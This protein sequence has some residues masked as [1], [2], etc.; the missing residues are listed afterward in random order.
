MTT[1]VAYLSGPMSGVPDYNF[2]AF[3]EAAEALRGAGFEVISPAELEDLDD[4]ADG[5]TP[6]KYRELLTRD[7]MLIAGGEVTEIVVLPGWGQSK[8]AIAEVSLGRAL[9]L[10]ILSYPDLW[11][12]GEGPSEGS[13][14]TAMLLEAASLVDGN[15]NAQYGDPLQDFRRTA[16]MWSAYF[17]VEV[18]PHDVAAA[19][20]LLKVSRIR[21][22]PG[23][24]DSWVDLAGYAACGLDCSQRENDNAQEAQTQAET[25]QA[26]AP[27]ARVLGDQYE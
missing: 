7:L 18:H 8:G 15:R 25:P 20:A 16:G 13:P 2:P 23:K 9:G 5:V 3:H 11:P 17:G 22:S 26:P 24:R 6:E 10:P 1:R 27:P 12:L 21:W 19:M 4:H 14:R